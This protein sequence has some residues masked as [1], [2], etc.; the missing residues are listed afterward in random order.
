VIDF[1]LASFGPVGYDALTNAFFG[2]MW[3]ESNVRYRFSNEQ[4]RN[5]IAELD[6]VA[7]TRSLPAIS[8]YTDDFL[9]LKAIWSTSKDK[10]S[11][12][13]PESSPEFWTWRVKVRDWCILQYLKGEKIDTDMLE[14]VG[15]AL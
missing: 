8:E 6:A 3:P 4:I 14:E 11:E 1:E 15:S 9:V 13:N 10:G 12:E 2:R 5:Y 7:A